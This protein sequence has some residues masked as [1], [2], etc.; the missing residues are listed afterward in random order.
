VFGRNSA[1]TGLL[2]LTVLLGCATAGVRNIG[3]GAGYNI[4]HVNAEPKPGTP[5]VEG[6]T[7]ALSV[8]V[9]YG[10]WVADSGSIVLVPQDE[11]NRTLLA[12]RAQVFRRVRGG[13][14]QSTL[15]DTLTLPPSVRQLRLFIPL[16]PDGFTVTGGELLIVY[17]V[18]RA[19]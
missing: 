7:V 10:L 17:P 15:S 6:Q 11:S 16:V 1:A 2:S 13:A 12:A 5:L 8:T 4:S 14:G 9:R 18:W 19:R 3:R